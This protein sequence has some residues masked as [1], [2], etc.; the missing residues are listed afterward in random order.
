MINYFSFC[1]R[2]QYAPMPFSAVK[3]VLGTLLIVSC[4]II[5]FPSVVHAKADMVRTDARMTEKSDVRV[6]LASHT[7]STSAYTLVQ[8]SSGT[9]GTSVIIWGGGFPA[10][11]TVNLHL[12]G[13]AGRARSPRSSAA[14][15]SA[16]TTADGSYRIDYTMPST[17]LDGTPIATG[18]LALL[19]A[20]RDFSVTANATFDYVAS[21]PAPPPS[22]SSVPTAQ[23]S[24]TSGGAHTSTAISGSG[25]PAYTHVH[26]YLAK[27]DG[28]VG[29]GGSVRYASAQTDHLGRYTLHFSIPAA[30]PDGSA[31]RDHRIL[32][33]VATDNFNHEA[34]A[35]FR[36]FPSVS[37]PA[38]TPT[39]VPAAPSLHINP[40]HGTQG[41]HIAL[42]GCGFPAHTTLNVHLAGIAGRHGGYAQPTSYISVQTN[43]HGCYSGSFAM[44]GTWP[45]GRVIQTGRISILVATSNFSH[46]ATA[47]FEYSRPV[48]QSPQYTVPQYTAPQHITPHSAWRGEYYANRHLSGSPTFIRQDHTIDFSWG[49]GSPVAGIPIDNFSVRWTRSMYF[50]AGVYRFNM[51]TDDGMRVWVDNHLILDQWTDN[52]ASQFTV[53]V[54]ITE[55]HHDLRVEY[56]E[57]TLGAA[58]RVTWTRIANHVSTAPHYPTQGYTLLF[59]DSP[60]NNRRGQNPYFCSGFDSECNF[61]NCPA[62][63]RMVYGPFCRNNDYSYIIPGEYRVTVS[64]TGH[65]RIGATDYGHTSQLFGFGRYDVNLPASY[66]FCWHGQQTGGYGFETI[67]QST[68]SYASVSH[69]K[70]EYL[71]ACQ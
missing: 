63:H 57:H 7:S 23:V 1:W 36:Y 71:G 61:A 32:L 37:A 52:R 20:T 12:A 45:D 33:I 41:T 29:S 13:V 67:V 31:I 49:T 59:D 43:A 64:G 25:F 42:S 58:A 3:G 8:P 35:I 68:N 27:F 26:L 66:T 40:T 11:T 2:R 39:P 44:P 4:S 48:S 47:T 18:Q 21:T 24:P 6:E 53:D 9:A 51:L 62:N 5:L 10:H 50:S 30:W 34:S 65:V 15:A 69:I 54:T 56:Y 38:P 14:Y 19:V 55:G 17:W 16:T 46:E 60:H 70:V 28:Q 22:T